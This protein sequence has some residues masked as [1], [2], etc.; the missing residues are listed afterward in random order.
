MSRIQKVTVVVSVILVISLAVAL[1]LFLWYENSL[2]NGG[3]QDVPL[4][5]EDNGGVQDDS[6][7]VE[8]NEQADDVGDELTDANVDESENGQADEDEDVAEVPEVTML[9]TGDFLLGSGPKSSYDASGLDGI[10]SEFLQEELIGA[11][12]TMVNEEFPFSTRGTPMPDKQ[13]TFRL[14]PSYVSVFQELGIDVVTLANNHTLDYGT[15]ALSDT[16]EVLDAAGILYSGAGESKERAAQ[17]V[18]LDYGERK[19]GVLSASR[20]IPVVSWNIENQ[21]PGMLCTYDSTALVKAIEETRPL[22]DFLVIYVHW[23]VEYQ[24][25]PVEYQRKLAQEYIDA[26]ADLVVGSHPHV[27]QGIEY[28]QGKPIV[29]S[30]GN[31]VT[32]ANMVDTYVIKVVWDSD[33]ESSLI[34]VPVAIK[35][36]LTRELEGQEAQ[37]MLRFIEEISYDVTIEENGTVHSNQ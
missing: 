37:E 15:E 13:Y 26:G 31:F 10:L 21:Q 4:A 35:N 11:D 19:V 32:N 17:P 7:S 5:E 3:A 2:E 14:D 20:V 27:P 28:Y 25:Y 29:Y 16:F 18:F 30:L 1:A 9:F 22:C 34:V 12:L 8:E 36:S 33:G 6:E 23:G 24:D